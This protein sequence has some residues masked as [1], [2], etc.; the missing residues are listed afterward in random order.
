[1][2][3]A[4]VGAAGT[5]GAAGGAPA[6]A[7]GGA[8]AN[9]GQSAPTPTG[10]G[11]SAMPP[12]VQRRSEP[13]VEKKGAPAADPRAA[14]TAGDP[15]SASEAPKSPPKPPATKAQPPQ[16]PQPEFWRRMELKTGGDSPEVLEFDTP[17]Q[18]AAR[19]QREIASNKAW[20]RKNAQIEARARALDAAKGDPIAAAK[21]LAGEDF[22]P[23]QWALQRVNELYELEQMDPKDRQIKDYERQLA[24]VQRREQ[25]AARQQLEQQE[26]MQRDAAQKRWKQKLVDAINEVAG[27]ADGSPEDVEYRMSVLMPAV[28]GVMYHA[29]QYIAE[30]GDPTL[31][32]TA[33][34]IAAEVRKQHGRT[35]ERQFNK[36][37]VDKLLPATLKHID[38]LADGAL[39]EKLGA[40]RVA[41]IVRAHLNATG[42]APAP[43]PAPPESDGS[44]IQSDDDRARELGIVKGR[45]P[46]RLGV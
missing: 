9:P 22:D 5:A 36:V 7:G 21:A 37:G 42:G 4:A 25:E 29:R 23:D 18:L 27:P 33:Q 20:Q 46:P 43:A 32:P 15:K 41:R 35:F 44:I 34:E 8:P 12:G 38:G 31:E 28:A 1:M 39:L 17:D 3:V 14:S 13:V 2:S 11:K 10:P 30:I 16:P 24:E 26:Q 45:R 6:P 40:D 19:L